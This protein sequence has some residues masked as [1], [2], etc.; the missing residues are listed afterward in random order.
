[1]PFFP[2]GD[3]ERWLLAQPTKRFDEATARFYVAQIILGLKALH[4]AGG[5]HRDLKASNILLDGAGNAS[6]TDHGLSVFAHRCS[7]AA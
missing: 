1:M 3:L 2:H 7:Q 4:G 5:V 6:I